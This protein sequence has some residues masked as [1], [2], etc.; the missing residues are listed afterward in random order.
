MTHF[1]LQISSTILNVK[2]WKFNRGLAIMNHYHNAQQTNSLQKWCAKCGAM[3]IEYTP[4]VLWCFDFFT[5]MQRNTTLHFFARGVVLFY[6]PEEKKTW[7]ARK[8]NCSGTQFGGTHNCSIIVPILHTIWHLVRMIR[9]WLK[10]FNMCW[11]NKLKVVFQHSYVALFV[12][13]WDNTNCGFY[14]C[15]VAGQWVVPLSVEQLT[16]SLVGTTWFHTASIF[17]QKFANKK[18]MY[19]KSS[20]GD[21]VLVHSEPLH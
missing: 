14:Y 19:T 10:I 2:R 11:S 15:A 16:L 18:S 9:K 8:G 12:G 3:N 20:R 6:W 17:L 7:F 13:A 5:I 4:M 21:P 1:P